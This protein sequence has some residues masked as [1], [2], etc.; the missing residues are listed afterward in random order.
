MYIVLNGGKHQK[1]T[2]NSVHDNYDSGYTRAEANGE[3][4]LD[5][6]HPTPTAGHVQEQQLYMQSND[7]RGTSQQ[8]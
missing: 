8:M 3:Y 7:L 2:Q 1:W 4:Y 6:R 5:S